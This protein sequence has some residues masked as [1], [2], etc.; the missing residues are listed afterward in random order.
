MRMIIFGGLWHL[1]DWKLL[2]YT[3][4]FIGLLRVLSS[5]KSLF[6]ITVRQMAFEFHHHFKTRGTIMNDCLVASNTHVVR[7]H[8]RRVLSPGARQGELTI[9]R[10]HNI[11][12]KV[13]MALQSTL[14]DTIVC[15]ITGQLPHDDGLSVRWTADQPNRSVSFHCT[16]ILTARGIPTH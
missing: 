6:I 5:E 15:L 1:T 4:T 2:T 13:G 10:D 12:H 11:T 8:R 7:S 14:G 9:R 3:T 16:I